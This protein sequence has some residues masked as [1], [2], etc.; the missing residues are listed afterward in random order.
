MLYIISHVSVGPRVYRSLQLSS[1]HRW[2]QEFG[3]QFNVEPRT[4]TSFS[5]EVFRSSDNQEPHSKARRR[6]VGNSETVTSFN[7]TA[8][9]SCNLKLDEPISCPYCITLFRF[10]LFLSSHRTPRGSSK[11]S[12]PKLSGRSFPMQVSLILPVPVPL[13]S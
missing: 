1:N 7:V 8:V 5:P 4:S 12:G 2:K 11:C 9:V 3:K 6:S 10:L 13:E